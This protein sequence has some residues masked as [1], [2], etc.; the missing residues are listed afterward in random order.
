MG[1]MRSILL[2]MSEHEWLRRN[3]PKIGFVRRAVRRFMPGEE[4]EAA[5]GATRELQ[6]EKVGTVLTQLGENLTQPEDA[7]KVREHYLEVYERIRSGGLDAEISVKPTQLGLDFSTEACDRN[8][9]ALA[10]RAREL[11][12]WLWIDMEGTPYLERTLDLYRRLRARYDNVGVCVQAYL[13]RT[14]DDLKALLPLGA[15]IRLVKGAYREPPD[16]AFPRKRDVDRNYLQLAE[17]LL[18]AQQRSGIRAIFGTHDGKLIRQIE[19][20]AR[21][22]GL[23]ANRLEFQMLYGIQR[24]EQKRLA[25]AGYAFRVL[26]S[27]GS[28][29]YAWYMRRLAERPANVWFVVRSLFSR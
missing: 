17:T 11:G 27:Y 14:A 1:M 26:I 10:R 29:W 25:R 19:E 20:R 22:M 21:A 23:P 28:A 8:L 2:A 6:A 12:N 9:D 7:D 18:E 16:K 3:A 4:L 5:L 13:Y 24:E 15:N